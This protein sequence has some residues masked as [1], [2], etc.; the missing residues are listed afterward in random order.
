MSSGANSCACLCV[1]SFVVMLFVLIFGLDLY[2]Y[3]CYSSSV[4]EAGQLKPSVIINTYDVWRNVTTYRRHGDSSNTF[5][6]IHHDEPQ[7]GWTMK[8]YFYIEVLPQNL[9]TN[10]TYIS[11]DFSSEYLCNATVSSLEP[12]SI[13]E[14]INVLYLW[15]Y[16]VEKEHRRCSIQL[17]KYRN[18]AIDAF[19]MFSISGLF[20]GVPLILFLVALCSQTICFQW[21]EERVNDCRSRNKKLTKTQSQGR[22]HLYEM[23]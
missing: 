3:S 7:K 10:N 16:D 1:V 9:N 21:I 17:K 13:G 19:V 11:A 8:E 4:C 20:L 18:R 5:L 15:E 12:Y 22:A 23:V 6:K 14:E 2:F